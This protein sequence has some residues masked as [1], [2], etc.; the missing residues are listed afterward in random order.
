MINLFT[1]DCQYTK[2]HVLKYNLY[3]IDHGLLNVNNVTQ[4]GL[5]SEERQTVLQL[6]QFLKNGQC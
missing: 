2:L 1:C 5:V 6:N 4:F 3:I